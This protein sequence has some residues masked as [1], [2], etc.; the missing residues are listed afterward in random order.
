MPPGAL[1]ALAVL[2]ALAGC[3]GSHRPVGGP[4]TAYSEQGLATWYGPRDGSPTASG[5]RYRATAYTAAHLHL[6]FGT[7]L[8][9]ENLHN[10]RRTIV[11]V[12]DRGPFTRGR[13]LDVSVAAA[14][15]LDMIEAG[16]VPVRLIVIP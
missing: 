1:A 13:I 5:E 15:A 8:L 14:K 7:R 9:V 12:N 16:V 10:H 2:L 4:Q 11:R 3:A 6:R